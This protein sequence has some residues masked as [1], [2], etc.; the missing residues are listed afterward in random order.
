MVAAMNRVGQSVEDMPVA[1]PEMMF[2]AVPVTDCSLMAT[3]G[4]LWMPV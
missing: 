2:V 1:S 4:F 3:T